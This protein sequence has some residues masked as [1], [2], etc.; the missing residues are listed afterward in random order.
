MEEIEDSD[1][2]KPVTLKLTFFFLEICGNEPLDKLRIGLK[3]I[4][5]VKRLKEPSHGFI[6]EIQGD[7]LKFKCEND[8]TRDFWIKIIRYYSNVI[9]V[10]QSVEKC[11]NDIKNKKLEDYNLLKE[12]ISSSKKFYRLNP[13]YFNFIQE[14]I[15]Y[16]FSLNSSHKNNFAFLHNCENPMKY[17]ENIFLFV[18]YY[19][20]TL[21][22][23]N[24]RDEYFVEFP[25]DIKNYF[26]QQIESIESINPDSVIMNKNKKY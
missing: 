26:V 25:E 5:E 1:V 21:E 16:Q 24:F 11:S 14:R 4:K 17:L 9:K 23:G 18:K 8:K 7:Y 13:E 15:L 2:K 3:Y 6:L 12:I 20:T 10:V 19:N 22:V